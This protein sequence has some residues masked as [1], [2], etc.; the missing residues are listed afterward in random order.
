MSRVDILGVQFDAL[1][2]EEAVEAA[3]ALPYGSRVVTPNPEIAMAA[4]S[5]PEL[6]EIINSSGLVTAD[7]IGIIYAAKLL[8]RKLPGRVT[9]IGLV[10]ALFERMA[11]RDGSVYLFGAKPG[12]AEK[13]AEKIFSDF[14]GIKIAGTHDGYFSDD[15]EIIE[16]INRARPDLL[17]VCLGAPKQE[18][19]MASRS[20]VVHAGLMMGLGGVLDVYAGEVKRAPKL[21]QKLGLEWLYRAVTQPS[22]FKRILKLPG[23][24]FAALRERGREK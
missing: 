23:F 19:W 5:D 18:K 24:L 20:G 6:M 22:R 16:D 4:R 17:L 7:G 3:E 11:K 8:G 21:F 1:T 12:V 10:T 15:S 13:A 9:G 14:P 2:P